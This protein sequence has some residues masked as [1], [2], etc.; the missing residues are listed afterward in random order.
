MKPRDLTAG[1]RCPADAVCAV[2]ITR[3]LRGN[4]GG[5]QAH[6]RARGADDAAAGASFVDG[7]VCGRAATGKAAAVFAEEEAAADRAFRIGGARARAAIARLL[8]GAGGARRRVHTSN[9]TAVAADDAGRGRCR[10]S[11]FSDLNHL[12]TARIEEARVDNAGVIAETRIAW[13]DGV[14]ARGARREQKCEQQDRASTR[15]HHGF[16]YVAVAEG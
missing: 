10:A 7:A 8:G 5:S 2:R 12:F 3:A 6:R 1:V 16:Y 11:V 15:S 13:I 9:F 14:S 4:A